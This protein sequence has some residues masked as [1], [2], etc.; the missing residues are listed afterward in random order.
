MRKHSI[1]LKENVSLITSK[2]NPSDLILW[3]MKRKILPFVCLGQTHLWPFSKSK[4][5]VKS[6]RVNLVAP[7][8]PIKY[9]LYLPNGRTKQYKLGPWKVDPTRKFKCTTAPRVLFISFLVS[10]LQKNWWTLATLGA[11]DQFFSGP[12]H[13]FSLISLN[14]LHQIFIFLYISLYSNFGYFMY[15]SLFLFFTIFSSSY[16]FPRFYILLKING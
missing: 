2:R 1:L 6:D 8:S 16:S 7:A 15:F 11:Y 4:F 10:S 5:N 13:K 3:I 12:W 14:L 9:L